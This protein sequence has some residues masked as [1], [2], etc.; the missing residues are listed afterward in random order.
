MATREERALLAD[1]LINK[2][3]PKIV[4]EHFGL[5]PQNLHM[6]RQ[7]G[8]PHLKLISFQNLAQQNGVTPPAELL[9]PLFGTEAKAA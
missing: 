2:V 1:D 9:A 4:S 7:R 6:W 3:G 5:T 8:I